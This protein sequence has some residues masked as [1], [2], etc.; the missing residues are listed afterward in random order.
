MSG[1]LVS[2]NVAGVRTVAN[3]DATVTTGI[4]KKPVLGRIPLVGV[5][6]SGDEQADRKV[7]GGPTRVAYAYADEDY[8]WWMGQ[9]EREL[10][11]GIFG[12][13]LTVRGIDVSGACVGE[14][15]RVGTTMLQVTS[16]RVPCYKLAMVMDDPTFV[17]RFAQALRPGAYL[18][19][20]EEGEI[21]AGDTIDVIS[22]PSH[23]ITLAT[24]THIYFNDHTRRR[25]ILVPDLP[26]KWRDWAL[27]EAN[28]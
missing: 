14:R 7:H 12:E 20:V 2:V 23:G 1:F 16:P 21:G 6:L 11:P 15:W 9:L 3:G 10:P 24:M 27:A 28:A 8:R 25:E 4:F 17:K 19:V 18:S 26:A 13:N 22:R 5:N